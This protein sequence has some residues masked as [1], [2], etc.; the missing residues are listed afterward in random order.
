M[1]TSRKPRILLV[2]DDGLNGPG[3]RPF[4]EALSSLGE[5]TAVVPEHERSADSHALTLRH[6]LRVRKFGERFYCVDGSPADCAR[7]GLLHIL[8][9]RCDL[10]VSG[11]N[12]GYNLG[13]DVI[14]S[15]T[16]AGALEGALLGLP[17]LAV[18]RGRSR[19]HADF[20]PAARVGVRAARA[21]LKR[22]LPRG[23]CLNVNVPAVPESR[24]RG[25][26]PARLGVRRYSQRVY[27][28][29]DPSG[30][31]YYW[32]CGPYISS[33]LAPGTDVAAVARGFCPVTPLQLDNSHAGMLAQLEGWDFR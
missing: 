9:K 20:H 32:I 25:L 14:Y 16:V 5:V 2:N 21:V 19:R 29:K 1:T 30:R 26:K 18:S 7:L 23:V 12:D 28:R 22:G 3:L 33:I 24:L 4:I 17:A 15:G 11:V 31:P 13:S 8:K 27:T 6:P 10:V